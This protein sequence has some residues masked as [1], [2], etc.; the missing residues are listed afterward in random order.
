MVYAGCSVV[1]GSAKA[2]VVETGLNTEIGKQADISHQ[3]NAEPLPI[4]ETLSKSGKTI[5]IAVLVFCIIAFLIGMLGNINSTNYASDT[6]TVLINSVA[7]GISAMPESLPA[8]C[9]ICLLYTSPSP[10]D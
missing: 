6:L 4:T 8:M 3:I 7:L 5:N 9:I 1:H 2:V 10:R